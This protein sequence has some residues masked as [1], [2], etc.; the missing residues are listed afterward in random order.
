MKKICKVFG[1]GLLFS[2]TV[3]ASTLTISAASSLSDAF[4]EMAVEFEKQYPAN[5][6]QLNF[7]SSGQLA[8]QILSGAPVDVFASADQ[9]TMN[10][11]QEKN[12]IKASDRFNF[13]SNHL[14]V[15]V[16]K[17][18]KTKINQLPQ[19]LDTKYQKIAI[20]LPESVPVGRYTKGVLEKN[21]LWESIEKKMIRSQNVRQVLDYVARGEVDAGFVYATDAAI[22]VDKVRVEIVVPT[23]Q[24]ILYPIAPISNSSRYEEAK[25]WIAFVRSS[26]GNE[27]LSKYGFSKP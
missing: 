13:V 10:K 14:V 25:Q 18:S 6:V 2:S 26:K 17:S 15:I 4:K 27:I 24:K 20:G 12:L 1:L 23:D 7:A 11:L 19:L 5:R 21:N 8:Q 16:P 22:L 9:E 3:S